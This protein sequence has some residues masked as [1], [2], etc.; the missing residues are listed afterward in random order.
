MQLSERAKIAIDHG[1]IKIRVKRSGM[2]QQLTFSTK[3][4][5]FG[6]MEFIELFTE[7]IVDTSELLRV[8]NEIG[9]PV[10]APNGRAFPA[11]TSAKDFSKS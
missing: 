11:G 7:R 3:T 5:A 9:L 4:V 10:E 1:S 2:F 6:N 8:A